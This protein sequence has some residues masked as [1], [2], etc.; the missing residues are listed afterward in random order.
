M[1]RILI[2]SAK[3]SLFIFMLFYS[4]K[5]D[6]NENTNT[7][8]ETLVGF[9]LEN[10]KILTYAQNQVEL[11]YRVSHTENTYFNIQPLD[12]FKIT[13]NETE[14]TDYIE[15]QNSNSLS[16]D[17]KS[18]LLIDV[19]LNNAFNIPDIQF[20][21]KQFINQLQVGEKMAIYTFSGEYTEIINFTNN[22]EDLKQSLQ[23]LLPGIL[24]RNLN[25]AT[26]KSLEKFTQHIGT[27]IN[28][29]TVVL[30][31][32]GPDNANLV[33]TQQVIS[34]RG[35]KQIY[36][37]N[38]RA[39]STAN[40]EDIKE[41]SN[42]YYGE[43]TNIS[44]LAGELL[45]L[46]GYIKSTI[47]SYYK[48]TYTSF[49]HG[50]K[51]NEVKIDLRNNTYT[52]S[53]ATAIFHF[54][55]SEF[56]PFSKDIL[57]N[58][59]LTSLSFRHHTFIELKAS[60]IFPIQTPIYDWSVSNLDIISIEGETGNKAEF[61]A[62]GSIGDTATIFVNDVANNFHT[63]LS[64]E[65]IAPYELGEFEDPRDGK[66]YSIVHIRDHWW[67]A[68]NIDFEVA[69]GSWYYDDS[70]EYEEFG[71]LYTW[72]AANSACP[73]GWHLPSDGEWINLEGTVDSLL[74]S[75][76]SWWLND[77]FRGYTAGGNLK[78]NSGNFWTEPNTG[79]TNSY[80][81]TALPGG[82]KHMNQGDFFDINE[83]AY[84]WTSTA[85]ITNYSYWYRKLKFDNNKS[86]R[87]HFNH[88]K[89]LSVRCI[90]N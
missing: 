79:A 33:S 58:D 48:V 24:T 31:T 75:N 56:A 71:R 61:W 32:G 39:D 57:I 66:V 17:F 49:E 37:I 62:K 38:T 18:V 40:Y 8:P 43:L 12:N 60:T 52:G 69:E 81:F 44:E 78:D 80:H 13:E 23:L 54:N 51:D 90:K 36:T 19:S 42:G 28:N 64:C 67:F 26:Y 70:D 10:L 21:V 46:R 2:K 68:E 73:E 5:K 20:A 53:E 16:I 86:Y 76:S 41:I 4:C 6:E 59:T 82:Y 30:I 74:N 22:K 63:K 50:D 14:I 1:K 77:G 72:A 9:V 47:E 65:I 11:L 35:E 27:T 84:F 83:G 55:S 89:G 15:L 45:K 87:G 29:G 3:V 34:S 88:L 7:D 85:E 25:H